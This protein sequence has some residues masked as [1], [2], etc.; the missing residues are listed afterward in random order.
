MKNKMTKKAEKK[1]TGLTNEGKRVDALTRIGNLEKAFVDLTK[2]L[3]TSFQQIKRDWN[4]QDQNLSSY[5]KF[6]MALVEVVS[7]EAE[8]PGLLEKVTARVKEN[9]IKQLEE[10]VKQQEAQL[11]IEVAE[12]RLKAAESI[13]N[14][15]DLIVSSEINKDGVRLNPSKTFLLLD[16]FKP[17]VKELL[18]D[19]K[20]G[21]TVTL[22]EGG[23]VEVMEVYNTIQQEVKDGDAQ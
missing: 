17:G 10:E 3:N 11:K 20:A 6:V 12:G 18:I 13:K 9:K 1:Q 5:D 15:N 22:P 21:E 7:K 14:D 4:Q 8:I 23:V 2:A 16:Q 19:K